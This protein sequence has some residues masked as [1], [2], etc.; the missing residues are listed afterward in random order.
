MSYSVLF[1]QF[2]LD[3]LDALAPVV[4]Q[5]YGVTDYDARMKIRR[6]WGFLERDVTGEDA[7]RIVAAIADCAGGCFAVDNAQLRQL[8]DSKVMTGIAM[9][10]LGFTPRLQSPQ[11]EV[12]LVEWSEVAVLAAGG[13]SEE[14]IRREAR[15]D[16]KR[17]GKMMMG[18]GVFM[19]TGIPLGMFGGKK[20]EEKKPVTSNRLVTFG[21]VIASEGEQF[22]FSVDHF[23]FSGLGE[24][25]LMNTA[26]N[27]RVF[28]EELSQRTSAKL[29][30]GARFVLH[31][32]SLTL[33]NY[34]C[35]NDFETEL[36]WMHNVTG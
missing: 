16:E 1:R 7:H 5:T 8:S 35:L 30:F 32:R 10:P 9:T 29:N 33:A 2:P 4:A 21:R 23:D 13:F 3:H 28:F 34:T 26:A 6:G 11:D 27:Y 24:R 18:L 17:A 31:K 15:G 12:R 19:V 20:K 36:L 22:A 14:F 25:K